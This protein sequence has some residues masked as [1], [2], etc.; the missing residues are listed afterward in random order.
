VHLTERSS[1]QDKNPNGKY[2]PDGSSQKMAYLTSG[3]HHGDLKAK[4]GE[5][6]K[7][8]RCDTGYAEDHGNKL[9]AGHQ[10]V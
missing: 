7:P 1:N 6:Q 8:V 9:E 4:H 2:Q 3:E 10:T 5:L